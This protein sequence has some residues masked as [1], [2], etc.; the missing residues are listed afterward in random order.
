CALYLFSGIAQLAE[1]SISRYHKQFTVEVAGTQF[2]AISIPG[3]FNHGEL[4][5]GT[6]MLLENAPNVKSGQVLDFG[7]G[8]GLIAT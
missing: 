7:C 6:K 8:A 3:V 5:A 2:N 4:D 1:F